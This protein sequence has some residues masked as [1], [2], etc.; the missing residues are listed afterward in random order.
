MYDDDRVECNGFFLDTKATTAEYQ[1]ETDST[2]YTPNLAL[3]GELWSVFWEY[4]NWEKMR[5]FTAF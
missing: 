3:T 4:G 5:K 1:T 2:K